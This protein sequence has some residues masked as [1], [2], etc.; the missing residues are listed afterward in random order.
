MCS[1]NTVRESS[2]T[3]FFCGG[4][5]F[6]DVVRR[7]DNTHHMFAWVTRRS[8]PSLERRADLFPSFKRPA[9]VCFSQKLE[10]LYSLLS[11]M[12]IYEYPLRHSIFLLMCGY[13]NFHTSVFSSNLLILSA[14]GNICHS[15]LRQYIIFSPSY[16][17]FLFP[18]KPLCW[19]AL[20]L[21]WICYI[22]RRQLS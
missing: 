4:D 20:K 6:C 15:I 9:H 2:H 12:R 11:P 21:H 19:C 10:T 13:R 18:V 8:L 22:H 5:P 1:R 17:L 7:P 3:S 16:F 14:N